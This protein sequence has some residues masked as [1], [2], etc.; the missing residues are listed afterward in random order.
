MALPQKAFIGESEL[1]NCY[2]SR[3][4]AK[5]WVAST[6][7]KNNVPAKIIPFSQLKRSQ[8]SVNSIVLRLREDILHQL[9]DIE[10]EKLTLA[11]LEVK[12]EIPLSLDAAL[13]ELEKE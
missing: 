7:R 8:R 10:D 12:N 4:G 3:E 5:D 11:M 13:A 6:A 9:E 1:N 2:P